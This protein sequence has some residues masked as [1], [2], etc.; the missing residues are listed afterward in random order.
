MKMQQTKSQET[1]FLKT[2]KKGT[3][4]IIERTD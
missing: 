4:K 2:E 1:F 3:K